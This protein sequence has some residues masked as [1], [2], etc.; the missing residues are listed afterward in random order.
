MILEIKDLNDS[1]I[2]FSIDE[3]NILLLFGAD[4]AGKTN[5]LY[6]ILGHRHFR[7]RDILFEGKSVRK[8]DRKSK[9]KIRFVPD[10]VCM[11]NITARDYFFML[12]KRYPEYSGED[13]QELC[14]YFDVDINCRLTDMTYNENKLA[15]IIGAIATSPKLLILDEPLNF[16]T[17]VSGRKLLEYLNRLSKKGMAILIT[18]DTSLQISAYCSHYIYLKEGG[19]AQY[20]EIK[21]VLALKKAV[22]ITK[23]G[24]RK[25]EIYDKDVLTKM[26]PE[27]VKDLEG[28]DIEI[29]SLTLEE[30]IEEDYTRWM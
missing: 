29:V 26:L 30:I 15:M 14:E 5:W 19:S 16:M 24:C 2:F 17:E 23:N 20:G 9:K 3:G 22:T 11:E 25:T 13:V 1:N 18:S 21:D 28:A 7:N 10:N 27:I 12:A 8:L 6:Q 4:D